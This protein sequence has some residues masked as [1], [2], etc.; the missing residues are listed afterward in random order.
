MA[1][2]YQAV[3]AQIKRTGKRRALETLGSMYLEPDCNLMTT[4]HLYGQI[5]YG[6][7]RFLP[8]EGTG[9]LD[10]NITFHT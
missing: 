5:M 10:S 7:K 4:N 3:A 6:K 9:K 1:K 2:Y 8:E